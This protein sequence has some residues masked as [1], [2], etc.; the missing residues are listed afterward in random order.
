MIISKNE[1]RKIIR[2]VLIRE[3]ACDKASG[4]QGCIRKR[5]KGWVVLSNKDG[6]CWGRQDDEGPCTYYDSEKDAK[7]ALGAYH[8]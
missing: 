8:Q 3:G 4:H 5:S 1:L 7:A 2:E 6:K